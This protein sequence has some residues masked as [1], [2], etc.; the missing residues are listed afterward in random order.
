MRV[1]RHL[2]R[3][4]PRFARPVATLGVFDGVHVGHAEI[5]TRVVAEARARGGTALAITFFPHPARILAPARA[6]AP[7]ASLRD[8]LARF[9][10]LGV[11]AT[12]VRRFT[13]AFSRM[14]AEEFVEHTL[15]G[16][17]AVERVIVGHN[18]SFGRARRGNAELLEALGER[19]GFEVEI[20][21]PVRA[22]GREASSSAVRR[23]LAEGDV[24]GAAG[25]LGRGYS[26][27]GRVVV[28][29]R[30]GRTIGFPTA[31][32]RPRVEPLL[33]DGVYAVRVLDGEASRPGV[34]NLG[35]NPTFGDLLRR[36]LEAHVLDFAGDLYGRTIRIEFVERIRGEAKFG[37][38][39]ELVAQI[40]RDAERAREILSRA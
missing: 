30:R 4:H 40:G 28:G 1:I 27:A 29:K 37:S 9:R 36:S 32:V 8:R 13:S 35:T 24:G 12:I 16:A 25:L 2:E 15:V 18:V 34:A 23:L 5:L 31:N 33:P 38:I 7:I 6:P 10:E 22:G 26:V 19:H 14:E 20:V 17:L 21:G 39:D 3:T 11:D